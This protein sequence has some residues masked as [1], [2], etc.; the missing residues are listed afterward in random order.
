MGGGG[1]GG[2]GGGVKGGAGEKGIGARRGPWGGRIAD[3][4]MGKGGALKELACLGLF[5]WAPPWNDFLRF[6]I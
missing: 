5:C 3:P 1:G 4:I 6:R 2:A